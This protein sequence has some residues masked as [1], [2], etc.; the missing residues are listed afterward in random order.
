MLARRWS[1]RRW[2]EPASGLDPAS[3]ELRLFLLGLLL[4][5]IGP[6]WVRGPLLALAVVGL[7]DRKT[8]SRPALWSAVTALLTARLVADWPLPDNHSYLLA[9]VGLAVFLAGV[10]SSPGSV[11]AR[12]F[13]WL[14]AATF[15]CAVLWKGLLAPDYLDGRFFTVTLITDERFAAPVQLLTGLGESE[16]ETNRRAFDPLPGGAVLAEPPVFYGPPSFR[17]LVRALTWGGL[18]LELAVAL[19]FLLPAG[20]RWRHPL[21]LAF[22][23]LTYALAPVAGFG[24]VLLV[25]GLGQCPAEWRGTRG[26]YLTTFVV[27]LLYAEVPWPQLLLSWSR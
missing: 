14:V 1:P 15:A 13:R 20:A 25:L 27:V 24:W 16:L 2:L 4:R 7:V 8:L 22:C 12:A 10:A 9:Y 11:L 18:A 19:A 5:P 23:G 3:A 6:W 17:W 21:L 26:M